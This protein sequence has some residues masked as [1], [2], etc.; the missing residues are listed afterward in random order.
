MLSSRIFVSEID[1]YIKGIILEINS[2][3]E[4]ADMWNKSL[5]WERSEQCCKHNS[6]KS[7]HV[8]EENRDC[9]SGHVIEITACLHLYTCLRPLTLHSTST[10]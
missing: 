2:L 9:C 4:S 3:L 8:A 10:K 6:V 7:Y 5:F 1:K